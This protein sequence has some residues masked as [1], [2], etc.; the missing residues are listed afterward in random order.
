MTPLQHDGPL[1]WVQLRN[2]QFHPS[3]FRKMIGR[4]APEARNGDLVAVYDR[5]GNRFGTGLLATQSQ[6]GLRML[7]FD[8]TEIDESFLVDR[9]AAAVK[10]RRET[11]RLDAV[12]DAYRVVHAEGDQLPGLIIDRFGDTGGRGAF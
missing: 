11:L 2:A 4:I 8:K 1:P 3:I 5:D 10:F 12:T 7:S 9:L 6:I